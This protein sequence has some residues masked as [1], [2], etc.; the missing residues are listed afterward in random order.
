MVP[1]VTWLE[2]PYI[3]WA[4]PIPLLL[5]I[6]PLIWWF[7]RATWHQLDEDAFAYRRALHERG[8][9]DYRP[10]VALTMGAMILTLQEYYGR[11]DFYEGPL[12][13]W[14][15]RLQKANP[16]GWPTRWIDLHTYNEMYLRLW[17]G[18]TR[19]GGYLAPLLVWRLFF[20]RD[21]LLDFGLRPTG[22]REHA[23]IYALC[24][25]VMVPV[26]LIIKRQPDFGSYYPIYKMAGRSWLDFWVWEVIY[27]AQFLS[28][29]IFFRGWWIRATRVFGVGAIWSMAVPYCMIHYG[30]PYLEA[31][32][33]VV[34]GVVLGSLSM[35]TRSVYAGFLVHGT[36]AILMDVLALDQ[37]GALPV[38]LAPGS[39][40]RIVF[41]YWHA[42]IWIAWA[43]AFVV[44]AVKLWRV[45]QKR[46]AA[47]PPPVSQLQQNDVDR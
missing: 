27:I 8:E 35:K 33:A 15:E 38:L 46:R 30:K 41:L 13:R 36:V 39:S 34:A 43:L 29:E 14:L 18:L 23:W 32:S 42:L 31:C 6:A 21:S 37:R 19:V 7:F 12:H 3:K 5:A 16:T 10:L 22:F 24:V 26:L 25:V 28:L 4:V 40:R 47:L 2:L 11:G 9:I 17:W 20:R 44:L 1:S 45:L